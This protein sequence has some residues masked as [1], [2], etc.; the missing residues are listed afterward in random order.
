MIKTEGLGPGLERRQRLADR[1]IVQ[2]RQPKPPDRPAITTMLHQFPGDHL[3]LTVGVG[4]NHQ[5]GGLAKQAFDG[6]V[7]TGGTGLDGHLP[8]LWNDRQVRQYPAFVT[9][10]V[11]VRRCG[12]QQMADAPGHRDVRSQPTAVA[13][14]PGAEHGRDVFG[15]GRFFTE[16]Q[17]HGHRRRSVFERCTEWRVTSA[18]AIIICMDVQ[19]KVARGA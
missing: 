5:F 3:A 7:L 4:G 1:R 8:L 14:T 9:G 16:I 15:L 2:R 11:G 19:Q 17:L 13:A 18:R 6:L 10:V 12:F